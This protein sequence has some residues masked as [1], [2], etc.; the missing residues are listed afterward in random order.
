MILSRR[1]GLDRHTPQLHTESDS[2]MLTLTETIDST[3]GDLTTGR[4][5]RGQWI[6]NNKFVRIAL[7]GWTLFGAS[8]VM[9][10]G[11]LTPAV[12][13]ISAVEGIVLSIVKTHLRN[14]GSRSFS[15]QFCCPD[16][17]CNPC[18]SGKGPL[19]RQ[20]ANNS[21]SFNVSE[22]NISH[23]FLHR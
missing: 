15:Q 17:D 9:A 4:P 13:V 1:L 22:Q 20:F 16:F 18:R 6:K 19:T 3:G 8:C 23:S 5:M 2:L 14:R 21:F 12:S 10:D 7:L 11:L